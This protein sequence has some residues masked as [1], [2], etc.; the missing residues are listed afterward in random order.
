MKGMIFKTIVIIMALFSA[1]LAQQL[2]LTGS[3][4]VLPI[5]Q[6]CAEAFMD[7]NPKVNVSVR[8]GGSSVGIAALIDNTC[9]IA[10][11]SRTIKTKEIASARAKGVNPKEHAIAIDAIAII[12]NPQLN[13]ED[14]T[15]EQIHDIFTGKIQNWKDLGGPNL[16]IVPV[17]R[18]VASGT[19]EVFKEKVLKNKTER[20]DAIRVASNQAVATTVKDTPGS[21]G[22]VGLGY[23]TDAVKTVKVNGVFP[24]KE[25]A[26]NGTYPIVRNL[27]MYTRG[28][29]K[30]VAKQFIDFVLSPEGQNIV[31]E[32]GFIKLK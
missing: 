28:E 23:L 21:I 2:V 4:T 24:S 15:T 1:A 9:D 20:D 8:G 3:T 5:A 25:T 18:D 22:Y 11:S 13:I 17:S 16:K 14:L 32:L 7:K 30:G 12:I 10:N 29:P 31:D 19:Y 27:Y 26:K 6:A